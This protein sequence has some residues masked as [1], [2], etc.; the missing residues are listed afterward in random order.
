VLVEE[1]I[2]GVELTVGVI[3]QEVLPVLEIN[4]TPCRESGERFYSW[5]L[6]ECQGDA[7]S[8]LSPSFSCPARLEHQVTARVQAVALRAHRALG[9]LDVSRTD[10]RLRSDGTPCVLEV[11]PLPGL[12]PWD[13]NFPMMTRAAG[14]SHAAM[15]QRIVELAMARYHGSQ[16]TDGLAVSQGVS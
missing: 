8:G 15:I 12:S 14:I 3:G 2:D 5:R 13:S 7:V 11:N 10:I 6:K 4:F 16:K 1:F 9:C